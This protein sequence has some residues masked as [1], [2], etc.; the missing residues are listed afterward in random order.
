M[1][2]VMWPREIKVE[3]MS[4]RGFLADWMWSMKESE[5]DTEDFEG[6]SRRK[7][8]IAI[9]K[10]R[11]QKKQVEGKIRKAKGNTGKK[12]HT[13]WMIFNFLSLQNE[14]K[15]YFIKA[16]LR[17]TWVNVVKCLAQAL[18]HGR[19]LEMLPLYKYQLHTYPLCPL[20]VKQNHCFRGISLTRIKGSGR[21]E[22]TWNKNI[23]NEVRRG[24]IKFTCDSSFSSVLLPQGDKLKYRNLGNEF[25]IWK[26]CNKTEKKS[27]I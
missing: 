7:D 12:A 23:R 6:L 10:R 27:T 9:A 3:V 2:R 17:I 8:G 26:I 13:I 18:I 15:T 11:L 16:L 4:W 14:E 24:L 1:R 20:G 5:D 22:R 19:I 25:E 21:Q